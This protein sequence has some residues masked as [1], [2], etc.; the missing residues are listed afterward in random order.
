MFRKRIFEGEKM[1]IVYF[2]RRMKNKSGILMPSGF[3]EQYEKF[4]QKLNQE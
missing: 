1:P 4:I 2:V 3:G